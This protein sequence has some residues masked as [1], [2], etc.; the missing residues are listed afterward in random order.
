MPRRGKTTQSG[1]MYGPFLGSGIVR[2]HLFSRNSNN[3]SLDFVKNG[4]YPKFWIRDRANLKTERITIKNSINPLIE[5][6]NQT[7]FDLL[8]TYFGWKI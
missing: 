1:I 7:A 6:M 3:E 8:V 5:G 2:L 4:L